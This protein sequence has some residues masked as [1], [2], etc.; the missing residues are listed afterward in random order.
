M[1]WLYIVVLIILIVGTVIGSRYSIK[2]FKENHAKKFLPFGVAF[3]IAVIS[4]I[5]Y[6]IVSK[7][8]TLDIDISL[9]WMM[10]N[11]G[12]F[13]ASGIIYFSAFLTKK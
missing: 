2:L 11:M 3:L 1:W 5:I 7:K 8:A 9:S 4:E 13:F 6:L 10:L 12:L